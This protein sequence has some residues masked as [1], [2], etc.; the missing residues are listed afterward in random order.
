MSLLLISRWDRV[1]QQHLFT[2]DGEF[3]PWKDQHKYSPEQ[4]DERL[5]ITVKSKIPSFSYFHFLAMQS[6]FFYFVQRILSIYLPFLFTCPSW[7][8][9]GILCKYMKLKRLSQGGEQT[10]I[11]GLFCSTGQYLS[12]FLIKIFFITI[13][14]VYVSVIYIYKN[15]ILQKYMK[16]KRLSQGG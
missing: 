14:L 15:G 9:Y 16:L 13:C 6:I 5:K 1:I 4:S 3:N 12:T 2:K 7:W 8:E 10:F 11:L